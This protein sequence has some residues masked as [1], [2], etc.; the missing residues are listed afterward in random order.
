M[1]KRPENKRMAASGRFVPKRSTDGKAKKAEK[2]AV[3]LETFEQ[4]IRRIKMRS[5]AHDTTTSFSPPPIADAV[6]NAEAVKPKG[7]LSLSMHTLLGSDPKRISYRV[8]VSDIPAHV[9][10][11]GHEITAENRL[12][13]RLDGRLVAVFN[14]WDYFRCTEQPE[15]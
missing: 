7:P 15:A 2:G 13:L 1:A 14:R 3:P 11:N 12:I 4:R 9:S 5:P 10:A 6:M 8:V